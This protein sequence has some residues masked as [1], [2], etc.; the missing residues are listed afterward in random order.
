[1]RGEARKAM[2]LSAAGR[3]CV[4]LV[5][6]K[7]RGTGFRSTDEGRSKKSRKAEKTGPGVKEFR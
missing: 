2:H 4:R 7:K 6:S 1:M 3:G 5:R